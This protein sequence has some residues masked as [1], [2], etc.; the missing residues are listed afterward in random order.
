MQK[1]LRFSATFFFFSKLFGSLY[2]NLAEF[3]EVLHKF[4]SSLACACTGSLVTFLYLSGSVLC[5]LSVLCI[6][7]FYELFHNQ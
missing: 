7:F 2:G 6:D 3:L 1:T 4:K 5:E